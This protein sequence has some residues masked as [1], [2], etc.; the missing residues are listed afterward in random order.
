MAAAFALT[1]QLA[2]GEPPLLPDSHGEIAAS[3]FPEASKTGASSA[4][5]RCKPVKPLVLP[6][7]VPGGQHRWVG[8]PVGRWVGDFARTS[9]SLAGFWFGELNELVEVEKKYSLED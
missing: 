3:P 1:W 4:G 5:K 8:L 2:L 9:L 7:E 6:L